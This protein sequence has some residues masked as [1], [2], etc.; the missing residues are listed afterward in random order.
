MSPP[1]TCEKLKK[2]EFGRKTQATFLGGDV[3]IEP[4]L[5]QVIKNHNESDTVNIQ[6]R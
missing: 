1:P 5:P 3:C 2:F 6:K 4:T